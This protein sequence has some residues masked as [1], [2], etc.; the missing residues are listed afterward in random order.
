MILCAG[1]E[2]EYDFSAL[3]GRDAFRAIQLPNGKG[4]EYRI[5][6]LPAPQ[7]QEIVWFISGLLADRLDSPDSSPVDVEF[8]DCTLKYPAW[9]IDRPGKSLLISCRSI[10]PFANREDLLDAFVRLQNIPRDLGAVFLRLASVV[11]PAL[12]EEVS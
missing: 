12:S 9:L 5:R 7:K 3:S 1:I 2:K 10:F 6:A 11:V 8:D 4:D